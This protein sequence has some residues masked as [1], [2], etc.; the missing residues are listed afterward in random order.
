MYIMQQLQTLSV[1]SFPISWV[2]FKEKGAGI[3]I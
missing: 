2:N 3:S 1:T